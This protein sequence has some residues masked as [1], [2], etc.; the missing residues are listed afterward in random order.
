MKHVYNEPS[1][2]SFAKVGITGKIFP[3]EGLT[4]QVEFVLVE[5][6]TGHETTITEHKCVFSY[7]ILSGE[8]YFEIEG[9]REECAAGD[10]VVIPAGTKFTY[11]GKMRLLLTV[12]PPWFEDQEETHNA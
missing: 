4:D 7:Y 3:I 12:V 6:E 2:T 11:K 1:E 5:T 9:E 10:L 8:G